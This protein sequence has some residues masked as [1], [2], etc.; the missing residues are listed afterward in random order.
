M[1]T[2]AP[3]TVDRGSRPGTTMAVE[4]STQLAQRGRCREECKYLRRLKSCREETHDK[5][6]PEDESPQYWRMCVR[7]EVHVR[8][9][10]LTKMTPT[11]A[12]SRRRRRTGGGKRRKD[13]DSQSRIH[14]GGQARHTRRSRDGRKRVQLPIHSH[15]KEEGC[16]LPGSNPGRGVPGSLA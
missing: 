5:G 1:A 9:A 16:T 13:L 6:Y 15:Q 2:A 4:P 14:P 12:R 8:D 10:E 11:T 3:W 7:C